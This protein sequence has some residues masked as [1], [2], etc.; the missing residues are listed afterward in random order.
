MTQ[1]PQKDGVLLWVSGLGPF[2]SP[3]R[4]RRRYSRRSGTA[5]SAEIARN[6]GNLVMEGAKGGLMLCKIT[7]AVEC[8]L[9]S[10]Q[11]APAGIQK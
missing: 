4:P 7:E 6:G 3:V 2:F 10:R 1:V 9:R 11:E 8:S 5:I